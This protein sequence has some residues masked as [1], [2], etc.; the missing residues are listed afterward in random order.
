[1]ALKLEDLEQNL[2]YPNEP[3]MKYHPRVWQRNGWIIDLGCYGWDWCR[4]FLGKKK[5]AG[6]DPCGELP[7]MEGIGEDVFQLIG[8]VGTVNGRILYEFRPD[9]HSISAHSS[10]IE[11]AHIIRFDDFLKSNGIDDIDI[12]KMNI[13]GM[14]YEL[15]INLKTPIADQIIV[16]FHDHMGYTVYQR[17]TIIRYLEKWY[18]WVVVDEQWKWYLFLRRR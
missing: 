12:L 5:V 18:D 9:I 10:G 6:V 8:F 4:P 14:E 2:F 11:Q 17:E 15:L 3:Y 1:M 16:S 7:K 13:E